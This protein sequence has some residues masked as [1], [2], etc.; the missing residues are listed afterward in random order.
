MS[1]SLTSV[2]PLTQKPAALLCWNYFQVHREVCSHLWVHQVHGHLYSL[3]SLTLWAVFDSTSHSLFLSSWPLVFSLLLL[4]FLCRHLLSVRLMYCGAL[5]PIM[6]DSLFLP[7][8][9]PKG[10]LPVHRFTYQKSTQGSHVGISSESC[11]PHTSTP[12]FS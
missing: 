9:S 11:L 12:N 2:Y 8:A 10:F 4:L 3:P 7:T 5:G 1:A 6:L